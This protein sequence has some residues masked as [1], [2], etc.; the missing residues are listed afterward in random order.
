MNPL[1]QTEEKREA[2]PNGV[3]RVGIAALGVL[4]QVLWIVWAALKLTRYYAWVQLAISVLAFLL[5]LRI[6]GRHTTSATKLSWIIV[7]LTFPI[8][9]VCLYLLFGRSGAVNIMRG[10]FIR[11]D[12]E[13]Q[14]HYAPPLDRAAMPQD[15]ALQ[16]QIHYLQTQAHYPA[17]RN[18]DMTYYGDTNAALEAQ[19]TD[20]RK[21]Q[22]FIFMEYHAIEDSIAWQGIEDILAERA[23]AGVEVR[24]F[25]DDMGSIGFVD[26]AFAKKLQQ[27]GIQCRVFNPIVPVLNV[28]MNNRDHRKITVID[29]E[30]A[31]TG[32]VNIADEYA[33][34]IDRFG[35]WKDSGIRLEGEGVWGLTAAFLN[36]WSFLGGELH[37]ERDYYRPHT[38][39]ATDG[40]CQPFLDGPQNNPDNPAEDTF[41]QLIGSARRFLYITTPYFIPDENIMRALCIAGDG[42]VDVRLMLPG[43]PDHWY[44]DAVADSYIGELLEHHVKV[45]RYTPGFLHAKSI[46]VDREAAFVGSVNFDYRSFE[47]HYECGVMLYGA[48]AIESLLEDMDGILDKSHA[49]T[50]EEWAHRGLLRRMFE[51]ILRVFSIWM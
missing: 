23:A 24:V 4:L 15:P 7:I 8:F 47:L 43:T 14:P 18:T 11:T 33:N 39:P 17:C 9:G 25:Y 50:P 41:L 35:Y 37:E 26:T 38:S 21:A 49:V 29:G 27:R 1:N 30:T 34:L 40:F 13:L 19:K 28:F 3:S 2:V 20:L 5:A 42:G 16:N 12:A 36:M 46:M 10:R 6:Y 22:H 32:G 48:S 31:Y 44:A 45:Y 51:P